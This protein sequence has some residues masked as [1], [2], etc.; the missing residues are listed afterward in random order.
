MRVHDECS[1]C[2][3][4]LSVLPH[5]SDFVH[6][7]LFLGTHPSGDPWT[8]RVNNIGV[9]LSPVIPTNQEYLSSGEEGDPMVDDPSRNTE[10]VSS[11]STD[12]TSL[13]S[14]CS[15]CSPSQESETDAEEEIEPLAMGA[16]GDSPIVCSDPSSDGSGGSGS[17]TKSQTD[18]DTK[19]C[20]GQGSDSPVVNMVT[21]GATDKGSEFLLPDT[22]GVVGHEGDIAVASIGGDTRSS[23][24]DASPPPLDECVICLQLEEE[25][26]SSLSGTVQWILR[27]TRD[28][29]HDMGYAEHKGMHRMHCCRQPVHASCLARTYEAVDVW[30]CPYCRRVLAQGLLGPFCKIHIDPVL[31]QGPKEELY[32]IVQRAL[33]YTDEDMHVFIGQNMLN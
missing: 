10:F 2:I 28:L 17:N 8:I 11:I 32:E 14:D 1:A 15:I 18:G 24:A 5:M 6:E 9:G 31:W 7:T 25:D 13:C 29:M 21:S 19:G 20:V 33:V 23:Q 22:G 27:R 30:K 26:E 3:G 4:R 16:S 12:D